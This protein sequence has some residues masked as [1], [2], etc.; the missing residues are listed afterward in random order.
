MARRVSWIRGALKDFAG[1]PEDVQRRVTRALRFAAN[2]EKDEKAK[3]FKGQGSGVLEIAL[4][5]KGDAFRV[6]YEVHIDVD[7]WV[8][9]CF[10]KKSKS[11]IK[12]P[13]ADVDLVRERLK[14]LR[15]NWNERR[16]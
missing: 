11:G 10:R 7:I 15:S 9:H 16:A 4:Q 8:L 3:P 13:Q 1:F 14:R 12:T 5:H 2:G 6:V